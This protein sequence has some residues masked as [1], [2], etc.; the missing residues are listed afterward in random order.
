MTISYLQ[1]KESERV[2]RVVKYWCLCAIFYIINLPFLFIFNRYFFPLLIMV[3]FGL[4]NVKHY[5]VSGLLYDTLVGPF[6][7]L[8]GRIRKWGSRNPRN[9]V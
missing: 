9:D 5:M 1:K 8:V 2:T 4:L 7:R 6:G 3:G